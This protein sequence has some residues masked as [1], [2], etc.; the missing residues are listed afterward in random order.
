MSEV[1]LTAT[2]ATPHNAPPRRLRVDIMDTLRLA[3]PMALTQLGQI[4]MMTTDLALLGRLGDRVM[5]AASLAHTILF[6]MFVIGA[7]LVSAV[8]PLLLAHPAPLAPSPPPP[9][10]FA[11]SVLWAR[12]PPQ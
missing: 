4:A 9:L 11:A 3:W 5:A 12:F 1:S 10:L 2:L 7:G 8:A 6:A